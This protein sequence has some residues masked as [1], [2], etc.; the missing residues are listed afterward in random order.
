MRLLT[1]D[2]AFVIIQFA[3]FAA[4]TFTIESLSFKLHV[5]IK[6][7]T[8]IITIQG[9][10]ILLIALAQLNKNLSPFP[11]P[12]SN[13][14]LIQTGLYKYIRHPIYTGIFLTAFSYGFYIGSLYKT[15]ISSILLILFYYK[16]VYE[17]ERLKKV[18]SEY[19]KYIN[20]TGRFFPRQPK[21]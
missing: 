2:Y 5:A 12:K 4:Y 13:S 19:E 1:K 8:L 3:L 16:S 21:I 9:A 10:L 14:E 15:I 20:T 17:E 18:F 11:T 7:V 6:A